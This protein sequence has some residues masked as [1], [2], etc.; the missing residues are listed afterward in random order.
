MSHTLNA[1]IQRGCILL[2]FN[3]VYTKT[4]DD[5]AEFRA[6]DRDVNTNFDITASNWPPT[7]TQL[8][9]IS[10]ETRTHN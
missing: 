4:F 9:K 8:K 5:L 7:S 3:L 10:S 2:Y 1:A 6:D